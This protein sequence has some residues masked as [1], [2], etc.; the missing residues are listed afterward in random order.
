MPSG[1]ECF[2][3]WSDMAAP[4]DGQPSTAPGIT[5]SYADNNNNYKIHHRTFRY[6]LKTNFLSQRKLSMPHISRQPAY[7]D[8]AGYGFPPRRRTRKKLSLWH[9]H[10]SAPRSS[11]PVCQFLARWKR[12]ELQY[13]EKR[14][15]LRNKKAADVLPLVCCRNF[16]QYQFFFVCSATQIVGPRALYI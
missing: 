10:G 5:S 13:T 16:W 8:V 4:Y 6:G 12:L 14:N 7:S 9:T 2:I 15:V 11:Y 1:T 3:R